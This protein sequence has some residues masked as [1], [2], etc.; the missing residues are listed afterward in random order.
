M[1]RFVAEARR[2]SVGKPVPNLWGPGVTLEIGQM[3]KFTSY[4]GRL[5]Y[6]IYFVELF[7]VT[8]VIVEMLL[9]I[10][11]NKA[12]ETTFIIFHC[13]AFLGEARLLLSKYAVSRALLKK[14]DHFTSEISTVETCP[15]GSMYG[16][17]T[18]IYHTNQP[19]M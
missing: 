8:L 9:K 10:L 15:I 6:I 19:F 1:C 14:L 11:G 17:S 18:Y 2:K 12:V 3:S 16:L 13:Q 5:K 7:H 4:P